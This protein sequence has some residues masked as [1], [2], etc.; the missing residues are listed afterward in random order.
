MQDTKRP[1][2]G[3]LSMYCA[4]PHRIKQRTILMIKSWPWKAFFISR[5]YLKTS[6]FPL[7]YLTK[8]NRTADC[9]EIQ[10]EI[11]LRPQLK[12]R[13]HLK[14]N[15]SSSNCKILHMCWP[16]NRKQWEHWIDRNKSQAKTT[17]TKNKTKVNSLT[18]PCV[19][20]AHKLWEREIGS[21][22]HDARQLVQAQV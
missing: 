21:I 20:K 1:S 22:I 7:S 17:T 3:F 15:Y 9:G 11:N 6:F 10:F 4:K 2:A 18:V 5:Q 13:M 8:E 16:K 12:I 14:P 19:L